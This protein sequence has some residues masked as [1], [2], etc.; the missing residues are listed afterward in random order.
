MLIVY[1]NDV[2]D[3]F[4]EGRYYMY[5]LMIFNWNVLFIIQLGFVIEVKVNCNMLIKEINIDN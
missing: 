4:G 5:S 1:K 2:V 3:A